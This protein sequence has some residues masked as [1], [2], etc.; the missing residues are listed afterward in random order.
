M[1]KDDIELLAAA[2]H[3]MWMDA[4]IKDG[5]VYGEKRDDTNMEHPCLVDY[6]ELPESEKKYDRATALETIRVIT[7]DLGWTVLPYQP[8][9]Q[10]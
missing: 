10:G 6:S 2:V 7:E 1:N 5:W 3:K 4:R 9:L 8:R